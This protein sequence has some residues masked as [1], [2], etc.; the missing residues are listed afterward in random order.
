MPVAS[1]GGD[2]ERAILVDPLGRFGDEDDVDVRDVV[3]L[4][5]AGLAHADDREPERPRRPRRTRHG[6]WPAP[7]SSAA[8][9]RP[10]SCSAAVGM[11]PTGSVRREVQRRDAEQLAPVGDPQGVVRAWRSPRS[12]GADRGAPGSPADRRRWAGSRLGHAAPVVRDVPTRWSTEGDGAA[13]H[14]EQPVAS[15]PGSA[16]GGEQGGAL[17]VA[18][19]EGRPFSGRSWLGPATPRSRSDSISRT[20]PSSAWSG[21]ATALSASGRPS[22]KTSSSGSAKPASAG[23]CSSAS[24]RPGSANP[25]RASCPPA[26]VARVR[27]RRRRR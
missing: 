20:S 6:R 24:A 5:A 18:V 7:A 3:E 25:S 19:G 23:S 15:R 17:V 13:E 2:G 9:A 8:S 14:G 10:A 11:C 4:A 26:V 21:S 22:W 16:Q 12:S 1:G 27:H